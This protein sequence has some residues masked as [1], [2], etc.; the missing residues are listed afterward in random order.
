MPASRALHRA[1]EA[2]APVAG[3]ASASTVL[4]SAR[5]RALADAE[6]HLGSALRLVLGAIRSVRG[7]LVAQLQQGA[8]PALTQPQLQARVSAA[9]LPWVD[10]LAGIP[11]LLQRVLE[12]SGRSSAGRQAVV[13]FLHCATCSKVGGEGGEEEEEEA[14]LEVEE[15]AGALAGGAAGEAEEGEDSDEEGD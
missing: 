10:S 2:P 5:A 8:S 11:R 12:A 13:A 7:A 6:A 15:G 4:S 9:V 14:V 3:A 1:A